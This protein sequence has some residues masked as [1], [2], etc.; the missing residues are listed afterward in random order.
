[1]TNP[2]ILIFNEI[3]SENLDSQQNMILSTDAKSTTGVHTFFGYPPTILGYPVELYTLNASE[4]QS[5]NISAPRVDLLSLLYSDRSTLP[6]RSTSIQGVKRKSLDGSVEEHM[7]REVCRDRGHLDLLQIAAA[8]S[9]PRQRKSQE[10]VTSANMA[11]ISRFT[12]HVDDTGVLQHLE[13]QRCAQV[14]ARAKQALV[15]DE[16]RCHQEMINP[17]VLND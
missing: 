9:S 8:L 4:D 17:A 16:Q 13:Q 6:K 10:A 14:I 1:M 2:P 7:P 5:Y 11:P 15:V 12:S 3:S